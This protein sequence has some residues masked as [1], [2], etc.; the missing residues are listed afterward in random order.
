MDRGDSS[1]KG[2]NSSPPSRTGSPCQNMMIPD[3]KK[4]RFLF[5]KL[6]GK[7]KPLF[8]SADPAAVPSPLSAPEN[9]DLHA[10]MV[11]YLHK[12]VIGIESPH[13]VRA[14]AYDLHK[15]LAFY[16]HSKG[17]SI[18][19]WDKAFTNSFV[20]ALE[21][22]YATGTVHRIFAT[23]TNFVRFLIIYEVIKPIDNPTTGVRLQDQ[24]LPPPQGI[25]VIHKE[26]PGEQLMSSE[27]IYN[28]LIAAAQT[29]VAQKDPANKKDRTLPCRDLA[30]IALLYNTGFRVDEACNITIAQL[31]QISTGDMW[32]RNVKCKGKKVRTGYLKKSAVDLLLQYIDKERGW[33]P[34]FVFL[35]W[36]RQK[37]AQPDIWRILN[38]I[39]LAAQDSLPPGTVIHIHPHSLRH[40]RAFN[41]LKTKPG[42]AAVAEQLG[43]SGTSQVAR[44][45]R[46]SEADMRKWLKDV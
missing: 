34:G 20:T 3:K 8:F 10:W 16:E 39:A 37:L 43:H 32:I 2:G 7:D 35:S 28:C 42:D 1:L 25:Q 14:K 41:L 18:A 46:R 13:T 29:F 24:E 30:I 17:K 33:E 12:E 44:Y 4:A 27:E 21:K 38:K 11:F 23:A 5:K 36:R 22:E 45:S 40:E 6:H 15:L 9:D 31:E 26:L 19:A